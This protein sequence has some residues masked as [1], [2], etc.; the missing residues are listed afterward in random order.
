MGNHGVFPAHQHS[1]AL[2]FHSAII[3]TLPFAQHIR[4][5][6]FLR[7]WLD[8][9][10]LSLMVMTLR[11]PSCSKWSI[12]LK[13]DA[14]NFLLSSLD[15][16]SYN[17]HHLSFGLG[18]TQKGSVSLSNTATLFLASKVSD[19][20]SGKASTLPCTIACA[21]ESTMSHMGVRPSKCWPRSA[22]T[23]RFAK[24]WWLVGRA[25]RFRCSASQKAWRPQQL[26]ARHLLR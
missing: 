15:N 7:I 6:D 13:R 23:S 22:G 25:D 9:F 10:S 3:L 17:T 18:A 4:R 11:V 12:S 16:S 26:L 1:S 2:G 5:Y 20:G 8:E 19:S 21:R 24:D 14:S